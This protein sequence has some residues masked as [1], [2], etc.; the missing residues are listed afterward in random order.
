MMKETGN[1]TTRIMATDKF[2]L[3]KNFTALLGCLFVV[4]LG[5]GVLLPVFPFF[6]E[7]I[8][9]NSIS[10]INIPFHFGILHGY[11]PHYTGHFSSFLGKDLRPDRS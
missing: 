4:A 5:Y 9:E 11:L 6:I 10:P 7:K 8:V 1:M 2:R 3:N